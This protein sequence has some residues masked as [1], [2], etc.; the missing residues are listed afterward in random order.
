MSRALG[1]AFLSHQI[2]QLE[3]SV[4]R[5]SRGSRPGGGRGNSKRGSFLSSRQGPQSIPGKNSKEKH[6]DDSGEPKPSGASNDVIH[7]DAD[8]VI[9]D[10]SI[11]VYAL[12]QLKVWCKKNREEVVI[13]P[14]EGG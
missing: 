14:L 13:I 11:L 8:I 4:N 12:E 9:V 6:G 5:P 3:K 2:E 7:K 1:A 10:A